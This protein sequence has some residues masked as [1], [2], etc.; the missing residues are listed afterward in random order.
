MDLH[1]AFEGGR[2]Q[3]SLVRQR[4]CARAVGTHGEGT[5]D[6]PKRPALHVSAAGMSMQP[7]M[8]DEEVSQPRRKRPLR[9]LLGFLRP[10]ERRIRASMLKRIAAGVDASRLAATLDASLRESAA[11]D[12]QLRASTENI[13]RQ[14]RILTESTDSRLKN[15]SASLSLLRAHEIVRQLATEHR[16]DAVDARFDEIAGGFS[17]IHRRLDAVDES[18]NAIGRQAGASIDLMGH[19]LRRRVIPLS[20]EVLCR[21]SFGWL[22]ADGEDLP[23]IAAMAEAGDA[24]EPGTS[25][26]IQNILGEGD[27]ALDVGA[28]IGTLT[29]VMAARVGRQGRIMAFEPTPRTAELLRKSVQLH[30]LDQVITVVETA[31]GAAS[32]TGRLHLG[33]TSGHNSLLPIPE[34][35]GS[36]DVPV[37][38]LDALVPESLVPRL[39]KIDVEGNEMDVLRG[40]ERILAR[41]PMVALIVEFGPSHLRRSGIAAAD[42]LGSFARHGFTPWTID[43]TD[44]SISA[45]RLSAIEAVQS[46]NLLM[47]PDEPGRWPLLRVRS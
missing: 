44:G 1:K 46:I 22:L 30:D 4:E 37:A 23:L 29:L 41:A 27:A 16:F 25:Q 35:E 32:G 13:G 24:L 42:W 17:P 28:H 43:E 21:T 5:F 40:M 6:A 10:I 15:L 12:V 9:K 11:I 31:V 18:L 19:A 39:V 7:A 8:P 3:G 2:K 36:V 34:G 20:H 45:A 33:L 14:L 26:V 47:L 38:P